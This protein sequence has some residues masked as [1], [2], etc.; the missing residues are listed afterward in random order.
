VIIICPFCRTDN[1]IRKDAEHIVCFKC[2]NS[3]S[4]TQDK[5]GSAVMSTNLPNYNNMNAQTNQIYPPPKSLR[6][7][8]LFFP[9]PMFYPG[10]Y[11]INSTNL[12]SYGPQYPYNGALNSWEL[13][14]WELD[15]Y[16]QRKAKYELYK[17]NLRLDRG[18]KDHG[19]LHHN[20][21]YGGE[22]GAYRKST[23]PLLAKL[24]QIKASLDEPVEKG[25]SPFFYN[26]SGIQPPREP[27]KPILSD[28]NNSINKQMFGD[29]MSDSPKKNP[30]LK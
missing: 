9:D 11:P 3:V 16:I 15:N 5:Q 2:H 6:M 26:R 27:Q 12:S 22:D 25:P 19:R 24:R 4:I 21:G 8:D 13:H 10:Y 28:K 1:K 29:Q 17:H 7:S 30:F 20:H 18:K 14:D 23:D